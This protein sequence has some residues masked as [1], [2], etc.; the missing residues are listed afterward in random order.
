MHYSADVLFK[1]LRP[2]FHAKRYVIAL[3]GGLDSMVLLHSMKQLP[4][5]QSI[6]ALHINHRLSPNADEWQQHCQ[7]T[8]DALHIP[9]FTREVKVKMNGTGLE[10]AARNARYDEFAEFLEAGDC[11]LSAHHQNDQAETFLLRLIRGSGTRGL[12][13]M[14]SSRQ[15]GEGHIFRPLLA[16]SREALEAYARENQLQWIEDESNQNQN[17]DRNF[18]R[19]E[20]LSPLKKRW[21]AVLENITRSATLAREAE[22]LSRE[23]A[24]IDLFACYPRDD[25]WGYSIALPYLRGCSRVRQK[26]AV[27]FW[28]EQKELPSPGQARLEEIIDAVIHA[29]KDSNPLVAWNNIECRRYADR[30]YLIN[31][32]ITFDDQQQLELIIGDYI[33]IPG[34]GEVSLASDM[35]VGLRLGR[36]DKLSVRFRQGGERCKPQGRQ[37]SQTLKKLLQEY[38]VP[39]WVRDRTPLIYVNDQFAAVGDFWINEGFAVTEEKEQGFVVGCFYDLQ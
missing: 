18:V 12:A 26:N 30:L 22:E 31:P 17:F 14:P 16:F 23:L 39:P 7:Q 21:P 1:A 15:V 10:D 28:I 5:S 25:R 19:K 9:F 33:T 35:G 32:P 2:A 27:R 24:A 29:D 34:L 36:D 37:H 13:G 8:C 3:S 20:I 4:I 6:I 38:E 11:L